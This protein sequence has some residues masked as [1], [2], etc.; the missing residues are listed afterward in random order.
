MS[1]EARI[2]ARG[3]TQQEADERLE[4]VRLHIA[5]DA[6]QRLVIEP[7]FPEPRKSGE[8]ASIVIKVPDA[9][10]VVVDTSNGSLY[11]DTSNGGVLLENVDGPITADTSNGNVAVTLA[12]GQA[13]PLNLDTDNAPG[14]SPSRRSIATGRGSSWGP[15]ARV[16]GS[17]RP[18]GGS[19]S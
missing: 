15:A 2:T 7:L 10:G 6:D 17:T 8:G 3:K 14:A 18:T 12:P 1:I 19:R 13:G 4:Q 5:R 11:V 16:R 9:V